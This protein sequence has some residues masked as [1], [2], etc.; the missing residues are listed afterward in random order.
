MNLFTD[1][2]S[3]LAKISSSL[4]LLQPF[5]SPDSSLPNSLQPQNFVDLRLFLEEGESYMK[6]FQKVVNF[7]KD[8]M[9]LIQTEVSPP[10]ELPPSVSF[11]IKVKNEKKIKKA[12]T[13]FP[14]ELVVAG[15]DILLESFTQTSVQK[16]EKLLTNV[17]E[18]FPLL[19]TKLPNMQNNRDLFEL[20]LHT[21]WKLIQD[22]YKRIKFSEI[23][24]M[25]CVPELIPFKYS[26]K[27]ELNKKVAGKNVKFEQAKT[28]FF[29]TQKDSTEEL[30]GIVQRIL[31]SSKKNFE[32]TPDGE[33]PELVDK[34]NFNFLQVSIKNNIHK[35]LQF[36]KIY[37][38]AFLILEFVTKEE[39]S[40]SCLQAK[41][42]KIQEFEKRP[43]QYQYLEEWEK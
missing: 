16:Y 14:K 15:F 7:L 4:P 9:K 34:Q 36:Y 43:R 25:V 19:R 17:L 38:L 21:F 32:I 31:D 42:V 29:L 27:G 12:L 22:P 40:F 5:F 2:Q 13:Q 24:L 28:G 35:R 6:L 26:K 30:I 18:I 10:Q 3:I 20:V 33:L 39:F 8:Q 1:F 37:H 11:E 41:E 23:Q